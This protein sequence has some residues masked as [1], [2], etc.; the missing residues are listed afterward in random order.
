MEDVIKN[1]K[2]ADHLLEGREWLF[3]HWTSVDA[4]FF[5]VW[6]RFSLFN[7]AIPS[8]PNYAAHGER[9]MKRVSVQKALAFEKEVQAK[10]G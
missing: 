3:D 9:M 8:F 5:W 1:F 10:G 6:R 4:Y 7:I 2:I